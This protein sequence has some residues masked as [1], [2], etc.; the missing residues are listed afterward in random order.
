MKFKSFGYC[1]VQG[2][3]ISDETEYFP[4]FSSNYDAVHFLIGVFIP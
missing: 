1:F 2:I 3:K 4:C